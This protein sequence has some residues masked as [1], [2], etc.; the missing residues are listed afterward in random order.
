MNDGW[1]LK[2]SISD[3][4]SNGDIDNLYKFGIESGATGGKLLGAGAG[5]FV[6]FYVPIQNRRVFLDKFSSIRKLDFKFEFNGTQ[7]IFNDEK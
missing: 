2:K 3:S 1:H 6:L 4:I 5:G 7:I